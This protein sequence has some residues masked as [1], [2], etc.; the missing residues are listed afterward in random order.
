MKIKHSKYRNT[1]LLFELLVRRI[2]ADTLS[3]K[4][5][6]ASKLLK[7]YFVNTELGKEYKLYE[8]FFQKRG[9]S[10]SK[11]SS[12]IST[13]LESSKKLSKQKL[14]REK[15]NLIKELKESYNINDL[16]NT[17][18]PEYKEMASLYQLVEAYNSSEVNPS[19]LIEVRLNLMEFLTQS[20]V[21]KDSVVDT[22]MEEFSSY[23]SDLRV[24]TYKI[25]LE[26]FNSKYSTLNTD[27]KRILREYINNVDST[28]TLMEFYNSEVSNLKNIFE[29]SIPN[30]ND[31]ALVIK[32]KEVKKF[33]TPISKTQ[34]VTSESLVDL[35]QFYSLTNKLN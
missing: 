14:K 9:I 15:Y 7:K 13:I 19:L 12:V 23:D 10:E 28:S 33:L 16:F 30:I 27:Q 11:A 3:G 31:K 4:K 26:K 5:S 6:P 34:K 29:Q 8:S 35:L 21:D 18:I 24:L 20:Q 2:T 1:G 32:L 25:L 17:K 22:V